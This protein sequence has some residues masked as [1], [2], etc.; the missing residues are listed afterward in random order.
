M[1]WSYDLAADRWTK[2]GSFPWSLNLATPTYGTTFYHDPSGLVV[3]YDG[4]TMWAYDV[5][6]NTVAKVRQQPDGSRPA[7]T[8]LPQGQVAFGYDP[9]DDLAVAVVIPDGGRL[10]QGDIPPVPTSPSAE[11]W[12]FDPATGTW[13]LETAA[14]AS[15]LVVCMYWRASTDCLP[16]NGRAVFDEASGLPVFFNRDNGGASTALATPGRID[17]YDAGADAWRTLRPPV[18][19][20][21]A[22][23]N[24]CESMPPVY[25]TLNRRIVCL[26]SSDEPIGGSWSA[27]YPGVWA[28]STVTGESRWLLEPGDTARR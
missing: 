17:A 8:G 2:V 13:H 10:H 14:A 22:T 5:D 3:L 4:T 11:T 27:S 16:T 9:G 26:S 21:G 12:T 25:D 7:G 15:D 6:A 18:E 24:W 19:G 23:P 1:A 28:F 20:D